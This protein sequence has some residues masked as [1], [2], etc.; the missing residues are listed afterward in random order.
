MVYNEKK[1]ELLRQRYPKGTRI[2]LDS[3]ENDAFPIPPG[4]KGTV[5][6]I[7]DA[8]NL[9]MKWD[10]GGSLSLIPGEDKFHTISQEGTEEINIKERIKAFDKAN[11]PLYI[12]DQDDGRFSLCLQLKEYG[13]EAFNAYAEEIGDPVTEDGQFYTHGNGYEWET[14][15][16]RAF[17]D[18]PNLSKIYFDCEAGGFFCY[19]DSLSLMEDLGSRFKAMVDDTE[20][21]AN[22]VSSAL[23]EANQDQIEEITEEVQM[24]MLM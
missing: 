13:Q 18:E 1:V 21:F 6:F 16:R 8:G 3:M 22:L 7:D 12:V 9:I 10:S 14:V 5:D 23:K 24:D 11:S 17:A 2:C 19:A 15:F 20:G 4:S